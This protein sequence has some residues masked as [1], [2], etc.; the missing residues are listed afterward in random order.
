M[1]PLFEL[2]K[3]LLDQFKQQRFYEREV[4]SEIC[5]DNHVTGILGTR[6]AGKTTF[7]LHTVLTKNQDNINALYVSADH[8]YFLENTLLDLVDKLYKETDVRLLCVD[9]VHKYPNWQQELKNI[10]DFYPEFKVLFS[11]S[12]MIDILHSKFDLSRR[13]TLYRLYGFSFRE[14]LEFTLVIKLPKIGLENLLSQHTKFSQSMEIPSILKHF[15]IYL[16]TGYFPFSARFTKSLDIYQA[17]ENIV[18]KTIYEDIATLHAIKTSSLLVIE[19]LYKYIV[20]SQPGELSAYKLASTLS[21]DYESIT[22]YLHYLEQAGLVRM[23]YKKQVG[24]A[25][26]RN[27]IKMYPDNTNFIYAGYLSQPQDMLLGKVR[28]TFVINQIQCA[29]LP[30]HYSEQGDFIVNDHLFEVGGKNKNYRQ[31]KGQTDAFIL[32]DDLLVGSP[33]KIP[34][35]LLG[36]V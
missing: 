30:I 4:F 29:G 18:Q 34:L 31:L 22:T 13:V 16:Q 15:K 20:H 3:L 8:V 7:L 14:Y 12:S 23:L 1:E 11:G 5:L 10:T 9:E 33:R 28:E 25:F 17:I 6:G 26:L 19:Q 27:P 21:K 36:F 2:Q 35:Y 32:A 24:K